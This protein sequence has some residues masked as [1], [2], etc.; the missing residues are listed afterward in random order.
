MVCY[1]KKAEIVAYKCIHQSGRPDV[2]T[3]DILS[4]VSEGFDESFANVEGNMKAIRKRGWNPLN[5][6]LLLHP[7]ILST[8]NEEDHQWVAEFGLMPK[9]NVTSR[10]DSHLMWLLSS[11]DMKK[12]R[13]QGRN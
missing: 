5:R 10:P 2:I 6:N 4:I 3:E 1:R 13:K 8:M 11:F 7:E 12:F 9:S